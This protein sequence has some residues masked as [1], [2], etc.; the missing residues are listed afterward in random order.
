M[1]L[2][3]YTIWVVFRKNINFRIMSG[4][5]SEQYSLLNK[6][7]YDVYY[8]FIDKLKKDIIYALDDKMDDIAS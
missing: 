3:N 8:P 4:F 5:T 1:K 6:P 7:Y 2:V